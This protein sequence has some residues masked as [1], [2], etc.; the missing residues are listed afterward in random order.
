M[1]PLLVFGLGLLVGL[2]ADAQSTPV[3][4]VDAA[5]DIHP[6]SPFIYGINEW[7]DN[8]LLEMMR[9]PLLRWGGDS[10]SSF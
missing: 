5:A 9:V 10:A 2:A 7:S 4:V 8:G 3:L 1:K 6:I